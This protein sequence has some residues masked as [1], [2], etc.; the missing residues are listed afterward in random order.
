MIV[1]IIFVLSLYTNFLSH[2]SMYKSFLVHLTIST[3]NWSANTRGKLQI[4]SSLKNKSRP[5]HDCL[6]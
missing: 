2:T 3:L 6:K 4:I 5:S 1:D